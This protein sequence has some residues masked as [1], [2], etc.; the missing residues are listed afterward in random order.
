MEFKRG[1]DLAKDEVFQ[2]K[3][4]DPEQRAYIYEER[5]ENNSNMKLPTSAYKATFIFLLGIVVI[6]LFGSFPL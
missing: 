6:A 2:A 3:I 5:S 4:K 1:K